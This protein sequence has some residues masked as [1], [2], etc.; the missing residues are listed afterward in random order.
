MKW[1]K[2]EIEYLKSHGEKLSDTAIARELSKSVASVRQMRHNMGIF[3]QKLKRS[4]LEMLTL[5]EDII[6]RGDPCLECNLPKEEKEKCN[7]CDEYIKWQK[8][9]WREVR[10]SCGKAEPYG[11]EEEVNVNV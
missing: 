2:V 9:K 6:R 5:A 10:V 3:K 8:T 4:G 1:S 7:G 11:E